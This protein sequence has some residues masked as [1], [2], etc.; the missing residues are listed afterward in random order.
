MLF[1]GGKLHA[2]CR[3]CPAVNAV[4]HNCNKLGHFAKVCK[5]KAKDASDDV[6]VV[7]SSGALASSNSQDRDKCFF[8]FLCSVGV[9]KSFSIAAAPANLGP[10]V[11]KAKL[12]G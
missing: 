9:E 6:L 11:I 1:C 3:S 10:A 5:S 2:N 4:C 7:S 8:D 12:K